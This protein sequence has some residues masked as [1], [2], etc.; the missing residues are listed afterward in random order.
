MCVHEL[1]FVL[2]LAYAEGGGY[3]TDSTAPPPLYSTEHADILDSRRLAIYHPPF[4][5]PSPRPS[6]RSFLI[7]HNLYESIDPFPRCRRKAPP[8]PGQM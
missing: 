2:S 6:L 3:Y 8:P 7:L 5:I 1:Y 4:E